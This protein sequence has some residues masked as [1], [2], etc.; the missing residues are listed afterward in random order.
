MGIVS[1]GSALGL[2]YVFPFFVLR[3]QIQFA[4][5]TLHPIL[6]NKLFHGPVGFHN[7]VRISAG[8]NTFLLIIANLIMRTRIPPKKV[9]SAVPIAKFARDPPYVF[10]VIG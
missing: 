7:G 3:N 10:T 5:G 2:P 9:G 1:A 4:G 8:L 6:L